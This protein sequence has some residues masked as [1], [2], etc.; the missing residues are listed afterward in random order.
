MIEASRPMTSASRMTEP[1]NLLP[2]RADR[3]QRRELAR[4]LRDRD[5][6]RVRDHERADEER[7]A[8]EREQELLQEAGE[9]VRVACV[10]SSPAPAPVRTCVCA[11]RTAR[12][13]CSELCAR[14]AGLRR[15]ADLVE[16]ARL[17]NRLC[18]VG[19]SK[20]ASVAPPMRASVAEL[21]DAR[22]SGTAARG[23][24]ACDADRVADLEVLLA[25][26]SCG[27]SRPR[28]PSASA[29]STRLSGL[30]RAC[31]GSIVKARCGAPPKTDRL[32]VLADQ[33]GRVG[34]RRRA[35][36]ATPGAPRTFASS[37][38]SN[39]GAVVVAPRSNA[40]LPVIDASVPL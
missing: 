38:S 24:S 2:R 23:P 35:P 27:R 34:R 33:V 9:R 15:D 13:C 36:A 25:V 10:V 17:P 18:A 16:L 26:R 37:D 29:P 39:G 22:R 40:D 11:G 28:S 4:P 7:D 20:T 19:R 6:E 3:A 14:D 30:N 8:A 32:A 5:R 31:V 21:D 12:I 1:Q